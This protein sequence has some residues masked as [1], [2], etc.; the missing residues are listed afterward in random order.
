VYLASLSVLF[1]EQLRHGGLLLLKPSFEVSYGIV[2][3][4]VFTALLTRREP[5]RM[6]V[7]TV[8]SL[9]TRIL[10]RFVFGR[11]LHY[12]VSCL[13]ELLRLLL[14][15][16]GQHLHHHARAQLLI[17]ELR[18]QFFDLACLLLICLYQGFSLLLMLVGE[19]FH[20]CFVLRQL[21]V[22]LQLESLF[23]FVK[24]VSECVFIILAYLGQ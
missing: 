15:S 14:V 4:T 3:R 21:G 2:Q 10:K 9:L 24:S 12:P 5:V 17:L 7:V 6:L 23:R 20:R 13:L 1:V 22:E 8:L 19:D 11:E 18:L 16:C